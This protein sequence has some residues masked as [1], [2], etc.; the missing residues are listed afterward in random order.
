MNKSADTGIQNSI[1]EKTRRAL[2]ARGPKALNMD[3][4]ARSA[5]VSKRTLYKIIGTKEQLIERIVLEHLQRNFNLINT[6]LSEE[7]PPRTA[8]T[9]ICSE[10][11]RQ[12]NAFGPIVVPEVYREYPAIQKKARKFQ[13]RIADKVIAFYRVNIHKGLVRNDVTPEFIFDLTRGIVEHYERSGLTGKAF[14][15]A[16]T[17]GLWCLFDGL[18][19]QEKK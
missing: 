15:N 5:G 9:R 7:A 2:V 14:E 17:S 1:V 12:L 11:P 10:F 8:L 4:L 3:K 18:L 19:T 6:I 16:L 13:D